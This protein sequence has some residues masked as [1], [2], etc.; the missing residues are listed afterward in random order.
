MSLAAVPA[1][2]PAAPS[3]DSRHRRY[4]LTPL[5]AGPTKKAP[6][7]ELFLHGQTESLA[8]VHACTALQAGLIWRHCGARAADGCKGQ[9]DRLQWAAGQA[10]VGSRQLQWAAGQAAS[11]NG[12]DMA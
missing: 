10:A 12:Y 8:P 4:W 9:Q 5:P 3:G 11:A 2:L 7:R 1:P 6:I